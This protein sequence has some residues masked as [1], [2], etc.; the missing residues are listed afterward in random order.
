MQVEQRI[1]E[2][3]NHAFTPD[4]L[5]IE[6]ESHKHAHHLAGRGEAVTGETH[7]H[8]HDRLKRLRWP[9]PYRPAAPRVSS[10]RRRT[11]WP[12]ACPCTQNHSRKRSSQC[13]TA[14]WPARASK[15]KSR[16]PSA[17][18]PVSR[19]PLVAE[20]LG[21]GSLAFLTIAAGI[22]AERHAQGNI[23]L[24]VLIT[25]L[26]AAAGFAVLA[27]ALGAQAPG[28]F[29][30]AFGFSLA[31]SGEVPLVARCL[32]AP[33]RSPQPASARCLLI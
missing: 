12:G 2:K 1:R 15:T 7:F 21:S 18:A 31:L 9:H 24:A 13:L 19:G 6:N 23:G 14:L 29:N 11:R 32:A 4:R 17:A 27:R 30:P 22:L 8:H 28:L 33:R 16:W 5:M 20:A 10:S 3:L 25:A 26:S